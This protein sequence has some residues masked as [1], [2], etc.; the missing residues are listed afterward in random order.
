MTDPSVSIRPIFRAGVFLAVP[1]FAGAMSA[2]AAAPGEDT[3]FISN[4]QPAAPGPGPAQ[5]KPKG[6]LD[7]SGTIPAWLRAKTTRFTARSFTENPQG[8]NTDSDVVQ[9]AQSNGMSK[10]C[11]Q[12]VGSNINSD[13]PRFGPKGQPQVV[14]LRGD[15]VN[16]CK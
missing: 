9:S 10:T 6:G 2:L 8:I 7:A 4:F 5:V 16:I 12:E 1:F 13:A 11:V 15:L 3:I 14:V